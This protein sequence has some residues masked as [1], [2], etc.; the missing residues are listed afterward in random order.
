MISISEKQLDALKELINIGVGR[1]ASILNTMLNAHI[2]LQVPFVQ[3]V[4]NLDFAR[5][6]RRLG[7]DKLAS[8]NMGFK[9]EFSGSS[10]LIFPTTSASRLVQALLGEEPDFMDI[11]AIRAGTL[12]EIGNV[13][14]N[15]VMGSIANMLGLHFSYSVPSFLEE[16][17]ENLICE[18]EDDCSLAI[19]LARTKFIIEDLDIDGDIFLFFE[20]ASLE[21][22]LDAIDRM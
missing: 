8:I 5:E 9:G 2:S 7:G 12:C 6:I 18:D 16:S 22:L 14:L 15:G 4:S 13:V 17:V 21:G 11:D 1:G 10:Q 20:V 19:V 3:V